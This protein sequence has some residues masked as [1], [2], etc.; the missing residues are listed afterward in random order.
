MPLTVIPPLP[1]LDPQ[2]WAR[3][4]LAGD[5]NPPLK[6]SRDRHHPKAESGPEL[7]PNG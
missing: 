4:H 6:F 3:V 7:R 5:R 2:R 1:G